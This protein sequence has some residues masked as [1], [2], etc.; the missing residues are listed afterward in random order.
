[1]TGVR[2]PK[3]KNKGLNP[4]CVNVFNEYG[5]KLFETHVAHIYEDGTLKLIGR[6][7]MEASNHLIHGK[8]NKINHARIGSGH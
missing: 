5:D 6:M 7:A 2:Y 3:T 1:M 4:Y 8:K